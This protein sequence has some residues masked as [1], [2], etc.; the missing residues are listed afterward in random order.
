VAGTLGYCGLDQRRQ[1]LVG[2]EIRSCWEAWPG[3]VDL[4]LTIAPPHISAAEPREFVEVGARPA[5]ETSMATSEAAPLVAEPAS[6]PIATNDEPG[7]SLWGD[8]EG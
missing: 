5:G 8:V 3:A 6:T 4:P 2:D 7:W 1:P